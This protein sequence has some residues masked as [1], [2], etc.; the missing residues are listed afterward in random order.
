MIATYHCRILI[1]HKILWENGTR[2]GFKI[3]KWQSDIIP[4]KADHKMAKV[5]G[6][7]VKQQQ[8]K[9]YVEN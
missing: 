2:K 1:L 6:Q 5:K 7:K 4:K 9:Y 3:P 8:T